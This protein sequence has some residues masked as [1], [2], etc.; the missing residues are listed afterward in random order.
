MAVPTLRLALERG[1]VRSNLQPSVPGVSPLPSSSGVRDVF[2]PEVGKIPKDRG[3]SL[4]VR[5]EKKR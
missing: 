2:P 1:W 3:R 4:L 5:K